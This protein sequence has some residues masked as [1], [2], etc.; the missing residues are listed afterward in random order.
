M[1]KNFIYITTTLGQDEFIDEQM[2]KVSKDLG[3]NTI[4]ID[5]REVTLSVSNQDLVQIWI[6]GK[7]FKIPENS[8]V[9]RRATTKIAL[10]IEK[11]L[12]RA[13]VV[14]FTQEPNKG[15]GKYKMRKFSSN[16]IFADNS[17]GIPRSYLINDISQLDLAL[18]YF[19]NEFPIILKKITGTHGVGVFLAESKRSLKSIVEYIFDTDSGSALMVQEFIKDSEGKDIRAVVLNGKVIAAVLRDNTGKDFRSNVFQGGTA[20]PVDMTDEQVKTALDAVE[21]LGLEYGGVDVLL[22][23][24]PVITEVNSP[25]DYSFVEQTTKK[26]ITKM[27]LE[28]LMK[29]LEKAT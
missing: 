4:T 25:C 1:I 11:L 10:A 5:P 8:I 12:E 15:S 21:A 26:P 3:L 19:N 22:S 20:K 23:K 27:I 14:R 9:Y 17:V 29:K 6:K 2:L 16:I 7:V 24:K 28:Y 13:G 18:D